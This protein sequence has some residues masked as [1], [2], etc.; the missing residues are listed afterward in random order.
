MSPAV[1]VAFRWAL[2]ALSTPVLLILGAPF[3]ASAVRDARRAR[4]STDALAALGAFAAYGVSAASV[5]RGPEGRIYFDTATMVLVLV[6]LGRFLEAQAKSKASSL[7]RGLARISAGEASVLRDGTE[8]ATPLEGLRPGDPV[9]VRPGEVVPVDG[10]VT[11]GRSHVEEAA[12]TGEPAPRPV[13]PGATVYG[14]AVNMEGRILVRATDVGEASLLG[15]IARVVEEAQLTR[16][17]A[18]RLAD[19]VAAVFLPIVVAVALASLAYWALARG[20]AR[21]GWMAALSTLVVACP[22]ALGIATPLATAVAVGRAA[23][24]GVLVRSPAAIEALARVRTLFLDKTG[25][26]T[27]GSLAVTS[28]RALGGV[29][30]EF[31]LRVAATLETGTGH[32][33]GKALVAEAQARGLE[34]GEV[35]E[36]R[37]EP[38]AGVEGVVDVDGQ[39][40]SVRVGTAAWVGAVPGEGSDATRAFVAWDGVVR[41]VAEFAD[42][43][44][45]EAAE[46][47]ERLRGMGIE[48]AVI[49]GDREAVTRQVADGLGI[50]RAHAECAPDRKAE[51]V[52]AARRDRAI[53]AMIGDGVNDA[54]ALAEADVGIS[55][56]GGADLARE[57]SDITILGDDLRRVPLLISLAR[58]TVSVVRGNLAWALGYNALAL[59]AAFLGFLHPLLA[60]GLMLVS[61]LFVLGNSLR[62]AVER[63]STLE[64]TGPGRSG[65][66]APL[67]GRGL[68]RGGAAAA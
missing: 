12:F 31:A 65:P 36:C 55:M 32:I 14:G 59:V 38:G 41:A 24:M 40:L 53:T 42:T 43:P 33:V 26:L 35:I 39:R 23:R 8:V 61:S 29:G 20:D 18:Q 10:A 60:A 63:G 45:A 52:A 4:V 67:T 57:S 15:R 51:I 28:M 62:L 19:N 9:V 68:G 5:A 49:S 22:C 34:L 56:A 21:T 47:V 11:D 17:P 13:G 50:S 48:P 30:E 64:Q 27:R 16:A 54:P 66:L 7:I 25:T 44:R 37:Q 3:L 58:A 1:L 2:L 6:T 46:V